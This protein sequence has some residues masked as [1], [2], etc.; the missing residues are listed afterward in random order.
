M[1][2]EKKEISNSKQLTNKIRP[3]TPYVDVIAIRNSGE[4][5]NIYKNFNHLFKQIVNN[6]NKHFI[7]GDLNMIEYMISRHCNINISNVSQLVKLN[8]K[9]NSEYN[10]LNQFGEKL[11]NL[12]ELKLSGSFIPSIEDLGSNFK[13]LV[14]LNL[15]NCQLQDL[16][17]LICFENL[18]ELSIKNNKI[19]DLFEIDGCPKLIY[20]NLENNNIEETENIT[21][22]SNLED[23][24]KLNLSGNPITNC[25]D[26]SQRIKDYLPWLSEIDSDFTQILKFENPNFNNSNNSTSSGFFAGEIEDDFLNKQN[27]KNTSKML[28]KISINDKASIENLYEN[29]KDISLRDSITTNSNSNNSLLLTNST[30]K[31]NIKKQIPS[32]NNSNNQEKNSLAQ[33]AIIA[34]NEQSNIFSINP[35]ES[36]VININFDDTKLQKLNKL[37]PVKLKPFKNEEKEEKN[38]MKKVFAAHNQILNLEQ[39][40]EE[41]IKKL[42]KSKVIK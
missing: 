9:V 7:E 16:S 31:S 28:E 6:E 27:F 42:N 29:N 22:L 12:K 40:K 17:G 4:N 15:D 36:N 5:K 41:L 24:Q 8:L 21:F 3:E 13:N 10:L 14:V 23:L 18:R 39:E 38:N 34:E 11:P 35:K 2:K 19:Y 25:K 30:F 37:N 33:S 26:Y 1:E 32:L 20:L